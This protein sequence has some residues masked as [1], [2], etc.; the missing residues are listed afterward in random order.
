MAV[1]RGADGAEIDVRVGD[2]VYIDEGDSIGS[3]EYRGL[4][5]MVS[6]IDNSLKV[7]GG[8]VTHA[9]EVADVQVVARGARRG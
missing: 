9:D 8:P 6:E 4:V 1:L 7:V 3:R 2:E 5:T